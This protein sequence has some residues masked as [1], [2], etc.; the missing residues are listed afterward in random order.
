ML[1][2]T[3]K[4]DEVIHHCSPGRPHRRI[5]YC[6]VEAVQ[7]PRNYSHQWTDVKCPDCLKKRI[8][9]GREKMVART[10]ILRRNIQRDTALL[11]ELEKI[12]SP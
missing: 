10:V 7:V 12:L 2:K 11:A 3:F 1:P 9:R 8:N 6:G 5:I 4:C